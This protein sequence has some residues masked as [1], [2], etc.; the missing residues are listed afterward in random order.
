[1]TEL[2]EQLAVTKRRLQESERALRLKQDSGR[3]VELWV[4][5]L[6]CLVIFAVCAEFCESER[7]LRLKQDSSSYVG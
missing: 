4:G 5:A 3:C 1:M 7:A 2:E 6:V